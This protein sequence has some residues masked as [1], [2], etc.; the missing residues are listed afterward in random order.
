[1]WGAHDVIFPPRQAAAFSAAITGART[2]V[3]P[4]AGHLPHVEQPQA[5]A[6]G[7]GAFIDGVRS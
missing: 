3:I 1:V 2:L 4:D 7:V 6:A 5:F